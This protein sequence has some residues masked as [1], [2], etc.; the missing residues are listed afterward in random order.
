MIDTLESL[1]IA[2]RE[3]AGFAQAAASV[4]S[5]AGP[6]EFSATTPPISSLDKR[7]WFTT[8]SIT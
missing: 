6:K 7:H 1:S 8:Q 5:A 2:M 4:L 3:Q